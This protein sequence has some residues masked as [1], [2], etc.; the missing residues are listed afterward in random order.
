MR[1]FIGYKIEAIQQ[2]SYY[3]SIISD[4]VSQQMMWVEPAN[5]H[6]TLVFIGNVTPEEL[7]IVNEIAQNISQKHRPLKI[8]IQGLSMFRK[9]RKRNI[10]WLKIKPSR[11]LY[12]LQKEMAHA[13]CKA[14]PHLNIQTGKYTPHI[15][16]A[17]YP[18]QIRLPYSLWEEDNKKEK[19]RVYIN[20]VQLIKSCK[21][22]RGIEYNI[23]ERYK[24]KRKFF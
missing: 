7:N 9:A 20:E 23:F 17:R 12:K 16:I 18:K 13:L 11:R 1:I 21:G 8:Q 24:L 14:L 6:F 2:L 19:M 15:T 3:K 22:E 4:E 5:L 10:L